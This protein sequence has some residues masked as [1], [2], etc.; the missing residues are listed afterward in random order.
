MMFGKLTRHELRSCSKTFFPL[1]GAA[2]LLAAVSGVS[3]RL[4]RDARSGTAS[5]GLLLPALALWAVVM[6]AF[7][8]TLV[9]VIQRFYRGLLGDEGYLMLTL[10]VTRGQ[11]LGSKLLSALLLE[12]GSLLVAAA[13]AAVLCFIASGE[14]FQGIFPAFFRTLGLLCREENGLLLLS[15][16][17]LLGL[18]SLCLANLHLYAAMALGHLA[19][20]H[21]LLSSAGAFLAL[22]IL[23]SLLSS[24]CI[25][26]AAGSGLAARFASAPPETAVPGLLALAAGGML[27]A[28]AALWA[29]TQW[30]LEKHLNLE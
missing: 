4:S 10:P 11:L 25:R 26:A 18:L 19:P 22:S 5:F 23:F 30:I 13:S 29:V 7:I 12:L 17:V 3:L 16:G 14:T 2:L 6:A 8:V 20:G 15:E 9:M 27:L 28:A 21:R 24:F 1:W